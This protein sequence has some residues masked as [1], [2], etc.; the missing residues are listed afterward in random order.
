MDGKSK[1][2]TRKVSKEPFTIPMDVISRS[3]KET[4]INNPMVIRHNN[5]IIKL[6]PFQYNGRFLGALI[7]S[8]DN[9]EV[10]LSADTH[11]ALAYEYIKDIIFYNYD[12]RSLSSEIISKY[13]DI[14]FLYG[15]STKLSTM[16]DFEAVCRIITRDILKVVPVENI[17]ILLLDE[18]KEELYSKYSIKN[19]GKHNP[20]FKFKKDEGI[21]GY[22]MSNRNPLIE[23][24]VK[25]NSF[26]KE[27]SYPIT[28]LLSVPMI[29]RGK[30]IGTINLS[31]RLDRNEFSTRDLKLVSS[32]ASSCAITLDNSLLFH[33]IKS[34]FWS[35]VK[36]LIST[37]DAK[38]NYTCGHSQRV[39]NITLV[40]ASE[41]KIPQE[42][43]DDI[44]LAALLHDIGKIGV[45]EKILFKKGKLTKEEWNEIK[46]HPFYS[47]KILEGVKQFEK[48]AIWVKHEHERY[49]G[50]GYPDKIKENEIPMASRIIS[51]ADAYDAMT[52]D[53]S[54]RKRMSSDKAIYLLEKSSGT[55]FD[56]DIYKVFYTVHRQG[57]I[58]QVV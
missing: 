35:A 43:L 28:S 39:A 20:H 7:A 5:L 48:I 45:P 23:C 21:T 40:I 38:D 56:P 55:Q 2:I 50:L 34:L 42:E 11:L 47:S 25:N 33:E 51:I 16:P 10:M 19:D 3:F 27:V 58:E 13:E 14:S 22:V 12:L 52:S 24:N 46:K 15:L 31:D 32:I 17:S 54:Y 44:Y 36:S 57:K 1:I 6:F 53:R 41:L 9:D 4:D 18:E 30:V 49:D 37:I 29:A 8:S 26:F